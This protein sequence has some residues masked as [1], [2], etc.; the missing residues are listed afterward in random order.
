M[1]DSTEMDAGSI[2]AVPLI[3]LLSITYTPKDDHTLAFLV[4]F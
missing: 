3:F 4:M 1:T 2:P